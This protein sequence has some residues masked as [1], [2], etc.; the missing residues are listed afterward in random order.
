MNNETM[1]KIR[2]IVH[3]SFFHCSFYFVSISFAPRS[4]ANYDHLDHLL[5]QLRP[6][7]ARTHWHESRRRGATFGCPVVCRESNAQRCP[8][9]ERQIDRLHLLP[10]RLTTPKQLQRRIT[11]RAMRVNSPENSAQRS[12]GLAVSLRSRWQANSTPLRRTRH[13][14]HVGRQPHVGV[15]VGAN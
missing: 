13:R 7:R 4:P 9:R 1:N 15:G 12:P 11:K 6:D 14:P 3:C 8:K 5:R 10:D 2:F